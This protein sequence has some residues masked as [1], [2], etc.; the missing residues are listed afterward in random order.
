MPSLPDVPLQYSDYAEWQRHWLGEERFRRQLDYWL[1]QLENA[2][3]VLHLPTDRPRPTM[4]NYH[5]ARCD[6]LLPPTLKRALETL[7]NRHH[8][9][10]F[11]VLLAALNVLLSRY[12]GQ[13][14]ICVGSPIAGRTRTEI[15]K[16]IGVFVNM[17]VL[18]TDLSGNPS[19][20]ELLERVRKVTLEAYSHQ[21][22]PFEKLVEVLQPQRDLSHTP[23]FQSDASAPKRA[24]PAGGHGR[25]RSRSYLP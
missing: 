9:T 4:R 11:M 2:A 19:F 8:A 1:E 16:L 3:P 15:E 21:D 20:L 14:D 12:S 10:L 5:G 18:R 23:L 22:V 24:V 13:H 17:L 7:C 25:C 6:V